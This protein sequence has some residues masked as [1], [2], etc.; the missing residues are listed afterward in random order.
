MVYA[1]RRL[2]PGSSQSGGKARSHQQ[3]PDEARACRVGH[4][5]NRLPA[6][7]GIGQRLANQ[8]QKPAN[9]VA[10]G[11]FGH[12]AAIGLV[13]RNL[14]VQTMRQQAQIGVIDRH[15]RLV[16]RALNPDYPHI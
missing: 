14:A 11:Q 8:G 2:A 1:H 3:G 7:P 4:A 10:G 16:A 15:R 9:M 5:V 12:D 6:G 13:H